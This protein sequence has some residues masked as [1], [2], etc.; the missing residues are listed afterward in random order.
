MARLSLLLSLSVALLMVVLTAFPP[1]ILDR[2]RDAVFDG[3]QRTAPRPY[4]PLTPVHIIDID[5][6]ALDAFGQWPWP[7]SYMAELTDRLFDHGA[8]A[9]VFD[10]L[11][12]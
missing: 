11:F 3:Y 2:A 10:V 4:D 12:P 8:A 6:A 1:P 7:R 5:E 9:V